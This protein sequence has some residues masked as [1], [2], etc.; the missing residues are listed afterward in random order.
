MVLSMQRLIKGFAAGLCCLQLSFPADAADNEAHCPVTR[1]AVRL[2]PNSLGL[3][4]ELRAVGSF[5]TVTC[6][7]KMNNFVLVNNSSST[8]K[9]SVI[10]TTPSSLIL[11]QSNASAGISLSGNNDD[12]SSATI[13]T[14]YI[15]PEN[16]QTYEQTYGYFVRI[17]TLNGEILPAS[18]DYSVIVRFE[19][20]PLPQCAPPPPP[21]PPP[22]D[23]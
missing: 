8:A 15:I 5:F 13:P 16:Q 3:A 1:N 14:P 2:T 19:L 23:F 12:F 22:A 7:C 17:S 18:P 20:S 6:S 21:P 10:G 9:L 11:A 4:T